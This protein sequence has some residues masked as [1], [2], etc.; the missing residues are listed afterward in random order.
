[1][2]VYAPE[3]LSDEDGEALFQAMTASLKTV[4]DFFGTAE[5]K[6]SVRV[7]R[8]TGDFTAENRIPWWVGGI[9]AGSEIRVQ[10]V[11]V[12]KRKGILRSILTHEYA[13]LILGRATNERGPRWLHEGTAVYL[14]GEYPRPPSRD[15]KKAS[16]AALERKLEAPFKD[17]ES[18]FEAYREARAV[19]EHLMATYGRDKYLNLLESIRVGN[20]LDAAMKMAL[21]KGAGEVEAE[22]LKQP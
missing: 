4:E 10:P 5:D 13:H 18:S 16:W 21:G 19:V 2:T 6:V 17:R 15:R 12:L 11:R 22:F 3:G 1:M 20:G 14:A 8:T 7:Y 9:L